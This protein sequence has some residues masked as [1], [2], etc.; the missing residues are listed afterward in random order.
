MPSFPT[1]G[2]QDWDDDLQLYIDG[3]DAAIQAAAVAAANTHADAADAALQ[4][5]V[6]TKVATV[7]GKTPTAGAVTLSASD[8]GAAASAHTHAWTDVTGKPAVIAAG[9]DQATARAAIDAPATSHTHDW[10]TVTGKPAVIASGTTQANARAAINAADA[11]ATVNLTGAQTIAGT[12]TFSS[13]PVVPAN[14]FTSDHI[15]DFDAQ[16]TSALEATSA[17]HAVVYDAGSPLPTLPTSG[18]WVAI[19]RAA[20]ASPIAFTTLA[21]TPGSG[22]DGTSWS[23]TLSRAFAAGTYPVAMLTLATTGTSAVYP[24]SISGGGMTWTLASYGGNVMQGLTADGKIGSA[25]YYGTGTPSGT[26]LTIGSATTMQGAAWT[27]VEVANAANPSTWKFAR[28]AS[29]VSATPSASLTGVDPLNANLGFI[30]QNTATDCTVGT[31]FTELGSLQIA[32]SAPPAVSVKTEYRLDGVN[33]VGFTG[34]TSA[35]KLVFAVEIP[36]A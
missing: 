11:A 16:V 12:K 18:L 15:S 28:S 34:A 32:P 35:S 13:P 3:Q 9:A 20:A 4:V 8:V 5:A 26:S 10:S 22:T 31:G 2:T 24:N 25:L 21:T 7:N 6:D 14:S 17:V 29:T 36:P 27:I 33:A 1:R 23:I 30:T 19:K